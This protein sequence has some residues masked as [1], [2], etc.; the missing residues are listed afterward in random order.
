[1]TAADDPFDLE[2]FVAAQRR[3]YAPAL[4]EIAAGE[5]CSPRLRECV[6]ALLAHRGL[7][8]HDI[9]GSPDAPDPRTLGLL[10]ARR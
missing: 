2:R 10:G 6:A 5:K 1:M 9:L 8:A 7:T 3:T 4:A